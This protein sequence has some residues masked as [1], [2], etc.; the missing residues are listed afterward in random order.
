MNL[1]RLARKTIRQLGFRRAIEPDFVDIMNALN[2]DLVLDVGANDGDYGRE[3]RDRGYSGKI[4]SFEPNPGAYQRLLKAIARDINWSAYPLALGDV[5]EDAHLFIGRND[6][7]SSMKTLTDFGKSTGASPI[8]KEL[9][10]I[11]RLDRFMASTSGLGRN[12]Y[13]KIDTQGFEMEV[14][15]G[16]GD[17]LS[18]IRAVQA[19]IALVHTYTN[20][21]DWLEVIQWMREQG[22]E[23]STAIPNSRFG[24]QIREF[25]FVFV[26]R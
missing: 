7:M 18:Q 4:L 26:R 5:D 17:L 9:V 15:R 11:M 25:D 20:E 12:I 14:L 16:A 21:R 8:N 19:E 2:I 22:F 23:V 1:R 13:L 6:A 24:A 10:R 3:I